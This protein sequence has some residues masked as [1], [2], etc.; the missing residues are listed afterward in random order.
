MS[1][2]NR[3][4]RTV[5]TSFTKLNVGLVVAFILTINDRSDYFA[6]ISIAFSRSIK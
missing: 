6:N 2:Q 4:I 1:Y 5:S 3:Q